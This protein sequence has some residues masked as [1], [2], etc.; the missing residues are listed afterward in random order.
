MDQDLFWLRDE[1]SE[2]S[3]TPA[4]RRSRPL[5]RVQ[6]IA[7]LGVAFAFGAALQVAYLLHGAL[8]P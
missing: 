6:E 5:T 3:S 7:V 8:T 4:R 1:T 2:R